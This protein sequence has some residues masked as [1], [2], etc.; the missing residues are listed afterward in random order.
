[1]SN[2]KRVLN[3]IIFSKKKSAFKLL[4]QIIFHSWEFKKFKASDSACKSE[5]R[6]C[7]LLYLAM[8][9]N[10]S[11]CIHC[12]SC[13]STQKAACAVTWYL[14]QR[15][16]RLFIIF[17][18]PLFSLERFLNIYQRLWRKVNFVIYIIQVFSFHFPYF[19]SFYYAW[20]AIL[21]LVR[22]LYRLAK[23]PKS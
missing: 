18:E 2:F 22:W 14:S 17:W 1:M 11:F 21:I 6:K 7:V 20:Q 15:K 16:K 3:Q 13:Y 19:Y 10:D 12:C 9:L 23:N 4:G 8:Q 5:N